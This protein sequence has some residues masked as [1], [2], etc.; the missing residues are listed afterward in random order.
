M[1][2]PT[3]RHAARGQALVEFAVALT[4]FVV[5]LMGVF[6][7]GMAIYKYNGVAQ[8]ARE[9]ARVASV[10]QGSDFS[11]SQ[12]TGVVATQQG[13][14]PG[15]SSPSFTC[16][17]ITGGAVALVNNACPTTAF[18]NVTVTAQYHALTPLLGL[19]GTWT[20]TGSS[21]AQIQQ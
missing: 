17:T 18:V 10:H 19:L 15:L 7:F 11:S 1:I 16:Q 4:V 20:M 2:H 8:A 6:D 9:I 12:I 3:M 14:I 13:L 5:L 21:T